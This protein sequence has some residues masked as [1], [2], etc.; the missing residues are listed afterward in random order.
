MYI[1]AEKTDHFARFAPGG[2]GEPARM[3]CGITCSPLDCLRGGGPG[4]SPRSSRLP[5]Q[6]HS[7]HL[8]HSRLGK[9]ISIFNHKGGVG[10]TTTSL[11]LASQWSKSFK[12][13]LVDAD[14]QANLSQSLIG[15]KRS[16]TDFCEIIRSVIHGNN[17]AIQPTVISPYLH[18]IPG[19]VLLAD[20][21]SNNQFISFGTE[22]IHRSFIPYIKHYDFVVIDCPNHFG[23]LVKSLLSNSNDVLIPTLPDGF[24][25][26]GIVTLLNY[27][28]SIED[29]REINLLGILFN[30]FQ[31]RLK[32]HQTILHEALRRFGTL[33]LATNIRRTIRVTEAHDKGVSLSDYYDD[34]SVLKD[35]I[36]LSEELIERLNSLRLNK[37]ISRLKHGANR[38]AN[39]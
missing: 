9:L 6:I 15:R 39:Y 35:Y 12:I 30:Q 2:E 1:G 37:V 17:P 11:N 32:Y 5:Y 4:S 22:V 25:L 26:N 34:E 7:R 16:P 21:E 28:Y 20:M 8:I 13:L 27:I 24:S 3:R 14:P 36:Q 29:A 10:K 19:S 23:L 18:L 33:V 38:G 31:P